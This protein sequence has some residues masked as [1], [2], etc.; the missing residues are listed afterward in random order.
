MSICSALKYEK[1]S[2][3]LVKHLTR[4]LVFPAETKSRA[5][6]RPQSRMKSLLQEN[7]HLKSFLDSVFRKSFKNT[8]AS[9]E[10]DKTRDSLEV[11]PMGD[12]K[13]MQSVV[14]SGLRMMS[15]NRH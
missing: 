10:D 15:N 8:D 1:L 4:N 3:E 12:L 13:V 5:H 6:A 9:R 11:K 14:K 7:D 2:A